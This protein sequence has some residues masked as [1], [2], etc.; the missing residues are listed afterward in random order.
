MLE[1]EGGHFL[2]GEMKLKFDTFC[3]SIL[4]GK[5]AAY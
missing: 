1:M 2:F 5:S 4:Y 3:A